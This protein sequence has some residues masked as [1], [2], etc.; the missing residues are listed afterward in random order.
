[1]IDNL[2]RGLRFKFLLFI[3]I[4]AKE[5]LILSRQMARDGNLREACRKSVAGLYLK[6][7]DKVQ[8]LSSMIKH[9]NFQNSSYNKR[10]KEIEIETPMINYKTEQFLLDPNKIKK[11]SL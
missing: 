1:M 2:L 10:L 7:Y 5:Q 4:L 11:K 9:L 8:K 6:N 3:F